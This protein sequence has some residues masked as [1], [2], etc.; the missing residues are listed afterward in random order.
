MLFAIF[1][2]I[3]DN[4]VSPASD[5]WG[6]GC[7]LYEMLT[8]YAVLFSQRHENR[9]TVHR[10]LRQDAVHQVLLGD[11][12]GSPPHTLTLDDI[13]SPVFEQLCWKVS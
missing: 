11:R 7:L 10:I 3:K 4:T 1:Q 8:G 12:Y 9:D 13:Q 5:S 2:L 6:A